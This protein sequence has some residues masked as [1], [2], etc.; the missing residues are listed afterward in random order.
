MQYLHIVSYTSNKNKLEVELIVIK[1]STNVTANKPL[2]NHSY[3]FNILCIQCSP[4]NS[5]FRD[6]PN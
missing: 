3:L 6:L 4:L 1:E 2:M 5:N